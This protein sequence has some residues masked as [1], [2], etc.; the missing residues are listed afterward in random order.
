MLPPEVN[1]GRMYSGAGAA[2]LLAA[3]AA[4]AGL[5]GELHAAGTGYEAAIAE[6][7][8]GWSGPSA[9]AMTAAAL[10]YL[11]WLRT[12]AGQAEQT[13]GQAKAAAAAYEA[14]FAMTVPPPVIAANRS[15][16]MAL[17]ATNFFGQNTAAIAATEAHYAE[18]W[19]QD[20]TAMY[21]Y[22]GSAAT[23]STLQPFTPAPQTTGSAG[24]AGQ[25]V[26]VGHAAAAAA[27]HTQTV[28]AQLS[29]VPNA[30]QSLAADP[31][32]ASAYLGLAVTLLGSIGVDGTGTFGIDAIGTFVIDMAGVAIG[33]M[34]ASEL[35]LTGLVGWSAP[36]TAGL[37]QSASLGA[38]SVPS[39]WA[40]AAG[41]A[42]G[43][44]G[45]AVTAAGSAAGPTLAA[46]PFAPMAAAGMA[47]GASGAAGRA[48]T[49]TAAPKRRRAADPEPAAALAAAPKGPI[50]AIAGKL[51]RLAALRDVGILTDEQFTEKKHRVLDQQS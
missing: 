46:A 15:L 50:T 12:T 42:A 34:E 43:S 31:A 13:A 28:G 20:A 27:G 17:L 39:A 19:A 37:G 38:L 14:A 8:H 21:T 7:A 4:W 36:I 23:A 33:A 30:L 45:S 26:A 2:P 48:G 32:L 44:A 47:G 5:A 25:A 3:A 49:D 10:P 51:R 1:S 11:T 41:S 22:A 29:A 24:S 16:L 9:A 6:I 40:T 35:P 18:M